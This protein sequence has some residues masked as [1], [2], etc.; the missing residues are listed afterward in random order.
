M[1][2]IAAFL[3]RRLRWAF[4]PV[5]AVQERSASYN[6]RMKRRP[7]QVRTRLPEPWYARLLL[8][9]AVLAQLLMPI[10]GAAGTIVTGDAMVICTGHG[11]RTVA[12]DPASP[13]QPAEH[14]LCD[15]C[16][17]ACHAAAPP[18]ATSTL[19]HPFG[20][21]SAVRIPPPWAPAPR[22]PPHERPLARAPPA[23]LV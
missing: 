19:A 23:H 20:Y 17:V 15:L 3:S 7:P 12:V 6:A 8:C 16:C 21:G 22:A 5:R 11:F 2:G 9:V 13:D 14:R 1:V 10:V 4:P 18:A